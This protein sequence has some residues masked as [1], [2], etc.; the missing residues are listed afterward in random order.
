MNRD[1]TTLGDSLERAVAVDIGARRNISPSPR[2]LSTDHTNVIEEDPMLA[3]N[4][5]EGAETA[6]PTPARR[7]SRRVVVIATLAVL[8]IGGAAAAAAV[9]MSSDD[10]SHGL[11]GGS[12]IFQGTNPS[13]SST[14][15]VVFRCTLASAPTAEVLNDYTDAAELFVDTHLHIAGGCRGRSADGLEWTCYLGQRAVDEGILASDLL[16]QYEPTPG[17]G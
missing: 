8:G 9:S 11:P 13:C 10:V 7:R 3:T 12:M 14:D 15:G 16:G 17:R 5:P 6:R 1:L 2:H 4:R